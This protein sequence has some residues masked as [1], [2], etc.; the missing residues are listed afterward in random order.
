M[1]F[2]ILCV[3]KST[4]SSCSTFSSSLGS[5]EAKLNNCTTHIFQTLREDRV[6]LDVVHWG[7]LTPVLHMFFTTLHAL[8]QQTKYYTLHAVLVH[9]GIGTEHYSF[10]AQCISVRL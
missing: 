10:I 7:I 4:N 9:V 6:S 5:G 1:Y 2:D 8:S 3:R